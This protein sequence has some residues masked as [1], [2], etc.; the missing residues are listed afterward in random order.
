[1]NNC[2]PNQTCQCAKSR[3]RCS[4]DDNACT[5]NEQSA[6]TIIWA[7]TIVSQITCETMKKP[8][9]RYSDITC[10]SENRCN[11]PDTGK[12]SPSHSRRRATRRLTDLIDP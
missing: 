12:C 6:K 7:Y 2:G 4:I 5:E 3:F 9:T 1:M 10:C 11:R 8:P